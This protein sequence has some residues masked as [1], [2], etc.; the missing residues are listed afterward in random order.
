[1]STDDMRE[2]AQLQ[3]QLLAAQLEHARR[4]RRIER[5]ERLMI[6][7]VVIA[8]ASSIAA[9]FVFRMWH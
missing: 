5:F 9:P 4:L 6:L 3:A 7:I 8:A 2:W 1:M